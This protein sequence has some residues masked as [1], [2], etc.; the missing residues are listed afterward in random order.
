MR[1]PKFTL[2]IN[3]DFFLSISRGM[4]FQQL[5]LLSGNERFMLEKAFSRNRDREDDKILFNKCDVYIFLK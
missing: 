2:F 1:P 5:V 3:S 4:D